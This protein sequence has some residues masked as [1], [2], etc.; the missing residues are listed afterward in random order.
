MTRAAEF[1]YLAEHDDGLF[2]KAINPTDRSV[3]DTDKV[4]EALRISEDGR[5]VVAA[6]V[7]TSGFG[8]VGFRKI[9][10]G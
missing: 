2:V 7:L 6:I 4:S 3:W 1:C 5:K 9:L 10:A 8:V